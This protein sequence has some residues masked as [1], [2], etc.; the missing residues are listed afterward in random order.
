M[1]KKMQIIII[2][3]IVEQLKENKWIWMVSHQIFFGG[4]TVVWVHFILFEIIII[5]FLLLF[6]Y[7]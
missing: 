1:K 3:M 5:G 4:I 6:T 7:L 2:M